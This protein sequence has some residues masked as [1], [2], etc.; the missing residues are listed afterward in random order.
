MKY[1]ASLLIVLAI[2]LPAHAQQTSSSQ[3]VN[4]LD[5][6]LQKVKLRQREEAEINRK[7]E[8]EFIAARNEQKAMLRKAEKEFLSAQKANNPLK[9]IT[10]GNSAKLEKLQKE[11]DKNVDELGDIYS[12]Y[13]EFAGDF[14]AVLQE[15]MIHSQFPERSEQLAALSDRS[16]LPTIEQME[17]LWVLVQEEMTESAKITT[18]DAPVLSTDGKISDKA[19][20]RVGTFTAV[21]DGQFLRYIPETQE[22]LTLSRQPREVSVAARFQNRHGAEP[23][24]MIIDPTR[25]S[26]LGVAANLPT[27]VEK[28]KQ[29]KEVGYVIIA[30]GCIGALITLWRLTVL[31][32]TWLATRRQLA[33]IGKPKTSNPLGRVI[34]SVS[35]LG[36]VDEETLQFKL[37]EAILQE[38]PRLE[39]GHGLIKLF[40]AIAPLMGLLGTV[41][42]M[43]AT[44]QAIAIF[45]SGDPK[46]M[47]GGISQAL[48]TTVLGLIVAIP[49]LFGH[50][51]VSSFSRAII[52]ILDEQSAGL[53]AAHLEKRA[54][55]KAAR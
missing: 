25:G 23:S 36:S 50:N 52:Q 5:Q 11:L 19:V 29:G 33:N 53:L 6:L 49:L 44:F 40:A 39:R 45:G 17:Q 4:S 21:S 22:L 2:T 8:A 35:G 14:S 38:I 31:F 41:I 3:Q 15:S 51:L 12:I 46:L 48:V 34:K 54:K 28:I 43:I 42:G 47:A 10:E 26:L 9:K 13:H 16:E 24:A 20:L 30:L 32:I 7:R 37:D 1:L 55:Q 27:T 18:F